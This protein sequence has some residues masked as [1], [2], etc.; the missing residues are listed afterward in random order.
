M[1]GI[2]LQLRRL[3]RYNADDTARITSDA[4]LRK[5]KARFTEH[6]LRALDNEYFANGCASDE[7]LAFKR[8]YHACV[9]LVLEHLASEQRSVVLVGDY[10]AKH[11]MIDKG[12]HRGDRV[13]ADDLF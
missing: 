7:R 13:P 8:D 2:E 4:L 9:S 3:L 12:N 11:Q 6:R 10:N 1:L 5:L